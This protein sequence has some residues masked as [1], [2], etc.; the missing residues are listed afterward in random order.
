MF[1]QLYSHG[2]VK[3]ENMLYWMVHSEVDMVNLRN[4]MVS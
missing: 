3:P 1:E 4:D 2:L